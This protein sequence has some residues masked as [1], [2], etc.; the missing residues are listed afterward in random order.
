MNTDTL[1]VTALQTFAQP[2]ETAERDVGSIQAQQLVFLLLWAA[3]AAPLVWGVL[4]AW[5]EVRLMF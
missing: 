5:N 1:N 4:K 2:L 3:V